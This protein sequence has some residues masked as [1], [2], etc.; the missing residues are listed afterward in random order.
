M[1]GE[2]EDPRIALQEQCDSSVWLRSD[3]AALLQTLGF[4]VRVAPPNGAEA[5]QHPGRSCFIVS[6]KQYV[7]HL[8]LPSGV[9][10][11][12]RPKIDPANV[13]RMLAYVYAGWNKDVYRNAEVLYSTDT[14]LFEPLVE[15]FCELVAS[16]VRRGLV[17]DYVNHEENLA[18][19]RG[20]IAFEQ[21]VSVNPMRPDRLFCRYQQQTPDNDDNQIVKWTLRY[22]T[23]VEAW[24]LPTVH[25]LRANLRYFTEVSLRPPGRGALGGRV[26]NRMNDDYRILHD[27]CRLFLENRALTEDAGEWRFRGFLLD[28][29]LLF[30]AFVTTAFSAAARGTSLTVLPQRTDLFSAPPSMP[31]WIRPDVTVREGLQTVAIVDAKYKRSDGGLG[32]PDFYQMLAYGTIL[33]CGRAY[34][35]YPATECGG[36]AVIQVRNSPMKIHV[37]RIDIGHPQC[38]SIAEQAAITVLSKG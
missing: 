30:E 20:R 33:C 27:F 5:D 19:L 25:A 14:F 28:M 16:R 6:P 18:V 10:L 36:D 21:Q 31:I 38:V 1:S 2:L 12:V 8:A 29:N 24:S 15:L 34:L 32:N 9:V 22:L 35:F 37:R 23:S 3:D 11:M 13:F 26:Y 17:Q 4:D 7:A